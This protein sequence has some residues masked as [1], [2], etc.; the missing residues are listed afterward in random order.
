MGEIEIGAAGEWGVP[1][2]NPSSGPSAAI[3]LTAIKDLLEIEAD[4][5]PLFR[6]GQTEWGTELTFKTPLFARR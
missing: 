2:G 3:E 6:R 1:C 5:S 4:V